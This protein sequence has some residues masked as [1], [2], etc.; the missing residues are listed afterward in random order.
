MAATGCA[1]AQ[2]LATECC[3][4]ILFWNTL[5]VR[6]PHG[7]RARCLV[8]ASLLRGLPASI[9]LG[10]E[11]R[12]GSAVRPGSTIPAVTGGRL[13]MPLTPQSRNPENEGGPAAD[14]LCSMRA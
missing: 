11:G 9:P 6:S 1:H 14:A 7:Q 2:G 13:S 3:R 10:C 5:A 12:G 8:Q 4:Q